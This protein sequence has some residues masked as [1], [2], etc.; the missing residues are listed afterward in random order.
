MVGDIERKDGDTLMVMW[1]ALNKGELTVL[2]EGR[3]YGKPGSL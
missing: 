3:D 2:A 1:V